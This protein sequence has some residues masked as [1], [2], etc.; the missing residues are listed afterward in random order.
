MPTK[1]QARRR[2][3]QRAL[4][5]GAA[6]VATEALILRKRTGRFAGNVVV[7]CRG[8]H[9]FTTLWIPGASV[10]AVRLGWWRV[11]RC[12]VGHHWSIVTPVDDEQL[13]EAERRA[14]RA[15][16]DLPVP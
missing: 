4:A 13:D 16:H 8:G 1:E 15:M 14:A 12:P 10:K 11:Q 7:R 5:I 2:R 9:T 3:K 6:V